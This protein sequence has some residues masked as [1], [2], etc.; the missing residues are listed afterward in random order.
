MAEARGILSS[1]VRLGVLSNCELKDATLVP[2]MRKP[3]DVLVEGLLLKES[4]GNRTPMELFFA[5]VRCW[6]SDG[7]L[8]SLTY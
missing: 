7:L 8:T 6:D 4:E 1:G 3:F 5:G 2:T